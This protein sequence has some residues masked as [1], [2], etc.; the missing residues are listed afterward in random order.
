MAGVDDLQAFVLAMRLAAFE[1]L[2]FELD[3]E[4]RVDAWEWM[5]L[6]DFVGEMPL[7]PDALARVAEIKKSLREALREYGERVDLS[8]QSRAARRKPSA[9]NRKPPAANRKPRTAAAK[10]S[11]PR[12][13][14]RGRK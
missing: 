6:I 14:N 13:R 4:M 2:R 10:R 12:N 5:D 7:S 11:R 9:A 1:L 8:P 3:S